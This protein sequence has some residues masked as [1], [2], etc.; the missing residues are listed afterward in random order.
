MIPLLVNARCSIYP[1]GS[2]RASWYGSCTF[3]QRQGFVGI[4]LENGHRYELRPTGQPNK[5]RDQNGRP[6]HR[7]TVDDLQQAY[8]LANESIFV[9]FDGASNGQGSGNTVNRVPVRQPAAGTSVSQLRDLV[10]VRA[11]QAENTIRRRGYRFV[12][13]SPSDDSAKPTTA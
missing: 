13:S 7:E 8:R 10:G 3:S 12:K 4:Q 11:G 5:Y 9:T 1:K 2:D 6:A